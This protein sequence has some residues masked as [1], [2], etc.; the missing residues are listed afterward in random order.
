MIKNDQN[1]ALIQYVWEKV[2]VNWQLMLTIFLS[3]NVFFLIGY[4]ILSDLPFLQAVDTTFL[5]NASGQISVFLMFAIPI[6]VANIKI[7]FLEETGV[8]IHTA[9]KRIARAPIFMLFVF[10][11][12][13]G[14]FVEYEMRPGL[15]SYLFVNVVYFFLFTPA[16]TINPAENTWRRI[17]KLY[18][19]NFLLA[20]ERI[21]KPYIFLFFK[22]TS[23]LLL[24]TFAAWLGFLRYEYVKKYNIFHYSSG[25][26]THIG[27]LMGRN[28]NGL[29]F[30]TR[31]GKFSIISAMSF[32][33]IKI[34]NYNDEMSEGQ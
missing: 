3:S 28:N 7:Q 34:D 9:L 23:F 26:T 24:I 31:D 13:C 27:A 6:A 30:R 2:C 25:G 10:F 16:N 19:L 21:T 17:I 32:D 22:K 15:W 1:R 4:S 20:W 29:I 14:S 33:M 5:L 18:S 11:V 8:P 12:I